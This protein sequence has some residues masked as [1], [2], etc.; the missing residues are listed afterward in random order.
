[1]RIK[2]LYVLVMFLPV[3]TQIHILKAQE[4]EE[5]EFEEVIQEF[6]ITESVYPQ[7]KNEIQLSNYDHLF[8]YKSQKDY[9][10]T[11]EIEYG[12]TDRFQVSSEI[13]YR[14]LNITDSAGYGGLTNLELEF[15]YNFYQTRNF[16]ASF[17]VETEFPTGS[18]V[19][20]EQ[21]LGFEPNLILAFRVGDL[22][23]HTNLGA[24]LEAEELDDY[25]VFYNVA[26][27]YPVGNLVPILEFN[28]NYEENNN[29]MLTPGFIYKIDEFEFGAGFP[30]NVNSDA[31]LRFGVMFNLILEFNPSED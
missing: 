15:M 5:G 11:F 20:G 19:F 9:C 24:E 29:F 17:C 22:Q 27:L 7:D 6:F 10:G 21:D 16:S 12:I 18:E 23:I 25:S 31:D 8:F 4:E 14:Y 3:I 30:V 2:A 1:M 28:G 26:A 13:G